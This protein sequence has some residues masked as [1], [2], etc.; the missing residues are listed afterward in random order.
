MKTLETLATICGC[1]AI[2]IAS[3]IAVFLFIGLVI[4]L[5]DEL[6]DKRR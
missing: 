2:I 6:K 5:I 1:C 3:I 4:L